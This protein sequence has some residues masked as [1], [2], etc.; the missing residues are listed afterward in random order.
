MLIAEASCDRIWREPPAELRLSEND[1]HIWR[2]SLDQPQVTIRRFEEILSSDERARAGRFYFAR[3]RDHFIAGRGILRRILGIYL[4]SDPARLEFR[5]GS[6]GKP[7]LADISCAL[8]FNLSHSGGLALYAVGCGKELGIDLEQIRFVAEADQ[9]AR[10][11]FSAMECQVF[12]SLPM[13]KRD[14]AF[15]YCWTRK[16][17]YIKAIGDGLSQPLDQFDVSLIPGEPARLLSIRGDT[18]DGSGWSLLDLR[19][20]ADY[21][22]AIAVKGRNY[23]FACWQWSEKTDE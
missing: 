17:A 13:D 2:A 22:A 18:E 7:A 3:D 15:F 8:S 21:A 5:Y 14:E 4:S 10:R 1:I 23:R 19:P 9:I 20:A 6:N 12:L 16:E 11:F